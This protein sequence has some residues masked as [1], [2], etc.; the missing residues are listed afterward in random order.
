MWGTQFTVSKVLYQHID[1]FEVTTARYLFGGILL[2]AILVAVEGKQA[3]RLGEHTRRVWLLGFAGMVVST[4]VSY[5]GLQ[6]TRPQNAALMVALQPL[7][8]AV[9]LR[10]SGRGKLPRSTAIAIAVAFAGSLL[11]IGRGDPRSFVEGGVGWGVI[12][13]F[14]AQFAWV[15]YT[16]ELPS[17][18]G[19]SILR[20]TALTSA[21]GGAQVTAITVVAIAV[22]W[23]NPHPLALGSSA[24]LL[25][26]MVLGPTVASIFAWNKGRVLLG[27]Q[28]IAIF[29][30]LIPVVAFVMEA[31]R[32]YQPGVIE[33]LAVVTVV[34]A[35]VGDNI[36]QRRARAAALALAPAAGP[37]P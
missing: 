22:G 19:W 34:A 30:Y 4:L 18:T 25:V 35:L 26:W 27:A 20:T 24:W 23:S 36:A 16:I 10:V 12:L 37:V 7:L 2:L 33:M 21:V 28:D 29:M 14:F 13:C 1:A 8:T 3:L 31:L 11:V 17:L 32:G 5:I 6:Y 9:V 15:L